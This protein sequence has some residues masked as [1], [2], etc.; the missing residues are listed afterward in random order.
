[1]APF[2][3][4]PCWGHGAEDIFSIPH[5]AYSMGARRQGFPYPS[6]RHQRRGDCAG[7]ICEP[8]R[9]NAEHPHA[10]T[11]LG[12]SYDRACCLRPGVF[13]PIAPQQTS[14]HEAIFFSRVGPLNADLT[15]TLTRGRRGMS[16]LCTEAPCPTSYGGGFSCSVNAA[17]FYAA[18]RSCHAQRGQVLTSRVV[19][20]RDLLVI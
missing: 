18:S 11:E 17:I 3:F 12:G 6:D 5:R 19:R 1:M 15:A 20:V 7:G 9:V 13:S 8:V 16:A 4:S 14:A 2:L 10:S